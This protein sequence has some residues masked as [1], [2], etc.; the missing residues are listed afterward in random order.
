MTIA[1]VAAML[2]SGTFAYFSADLD[3]ASNTFTSGNGPT[4]LTGV[5]DDDW[6]DDGGTSYA[7]YPHTAVTMTHGTTKVFD[8][9]S[10]MPGDSGYADITVTSDST[11]DIYYKFSSISAGALGDDIGVW[12]TG[13]DSWG[14]AYPPPTSW[15]EMTTVDELTLTTWQSLTTGATSAHIQID[16]KFD[17]AS[18]EASATCSFVIEFIAIQPGITPT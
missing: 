2:G 11:A 6:K 16:W 18:S 4:T 3:T 17:P 10:V 15:S 1:I 12:A 7:T 5:Y 8:F 14:Q 13:D 9:S